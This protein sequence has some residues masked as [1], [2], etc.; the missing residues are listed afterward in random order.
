MS[1]LLFYK[2]RMCKLAILWDIQL[3][4]WPNMPCFTHVVTFCFG[5]VCIS[6][7]TLYDT[8]AAGLRKKGV[9]AKY[10]VLDTT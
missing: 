9:K 7:I 3:G 10:I 6:H 4:H 8:S 2:F 5:D 1:C